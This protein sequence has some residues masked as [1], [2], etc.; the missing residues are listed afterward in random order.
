VARIDELID[1]PDCHKG[2]DRQ[3]LQ[4]QRHR[5]FFLSLLTVWRHNRRLFC[6]PQCCGLELVIQPRLDN[7]EI[8]RHVK[9]ARGKQAVMADVKDFIAALAARWIVAKFPRVTIGRIG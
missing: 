8:G 9:I 4:Q 6:P 7:L 1:D 3:T 5:C 2:G